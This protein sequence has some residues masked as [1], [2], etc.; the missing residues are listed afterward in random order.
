MIFVT[1]GT[2][3]L[4]FDRLVAAGDE[5][6]EH[7]PTTVQRGCSTTPLRRAGLVDFLPFDVLGH[8]VDAARVVVTHAGA[9]SIL[10]A[11]HAGKRPVV[12]PRLRR[13]HEAVDDH[14]SALAARL[15]AAGL[16]TVVSDPADLWSGIA[17]AE[18]PREPRAAS[19]ALVEDLKRELAVWIP[20]QAKGEKA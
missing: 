14:Q 16:V 13:F 12:V 5:L 4:P 20:S 1:V 8:Y 6:A 10:V 11:L 18:A 7:E 19:S 3:R 2:S 15:A 9:G 17:A